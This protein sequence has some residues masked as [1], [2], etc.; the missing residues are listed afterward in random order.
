MAG[1]F[2]DDDDDARDD[3]KSSNSNFLTKKIGP[4]PIWIYGLG[5]IAF[6]LYYTK[7][8]KQNTTSGNPSAT[9]AYPNTAFSQTVPTPVYVTNM[10]GSIG[11]AGGVSSNQ[12]AQVPPSSTITQA[13]GSGVATSIAGVPGT[14]P[15]TTTPTGA[16]TQVQGGS[17]GVVG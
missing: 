13:T 9:T 4:L 14:Y 10:P 11:P 16:G 3:H 15:S 6:Y 2:D 7:V 5:A 17:G 1:I 12:S 8:Y